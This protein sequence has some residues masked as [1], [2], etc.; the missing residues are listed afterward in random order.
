[1][2]KFQEIAAD[3]DL[4]TV[5]RSAFDT[6]LPVR[7]AWGYSQS[8]A[9]IIEAN[10]TEIPLPQLEHMLAS[11][12]AYLEM[13]MTRSEEQR[14]GSINVNE[15]ERE[16][17]SEKGLAYHKVSYEVTA[18][19]ESL[20]ASFIDEYKENYGKEGFDLARHF[21]KRKEATLTRLIIHWFEVSKII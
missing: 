14:Y 19:P 13:N 21:Q 2:Q 4:K 7:G 8:Q 18:I 17:V 1:M 15:L 5:I 9:T 16:T 20:Y 11:M 6:D 3:S 12:R 10:P